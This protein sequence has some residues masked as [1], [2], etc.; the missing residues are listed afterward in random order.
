[1]LSLFSSTSQN[2]HGEQGYVLLYESG[3]WDLG[4]FQLLNESSPTSY[5]NRAFTECSYEEHIKNNIATTLEQIKMNERFITG[6]LSI[7][8]IMSSINY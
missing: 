1:M 7:S 3:Q 4:R 6:G 8:C 5:V 2:G